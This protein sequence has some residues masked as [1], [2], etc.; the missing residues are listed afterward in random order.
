MY[1]LY[2]L[3]HLS[4]ELVG[5]VLYKGQ[6]YQFFHHTWVGDPYLGLV[7]KE[8]TEYKITNNGSITDE[9]PKDQLAL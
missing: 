9:E 7:H 4:E 8:A 5:I 2:Y 1:N 3:Q 6:L